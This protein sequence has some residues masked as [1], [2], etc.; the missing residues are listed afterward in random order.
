MLERCGQGGRV[1]MELTHQ[2]GVRAANRRD[3]AVSLDTQHRVVVRHARQILQRRRVLLME[4]L[5][6]RHRQSQ[7][8]LAF[9]LLLLMLRR[10]GCA[11]SHRGWLWLFEPA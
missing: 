3:I 5:A 8:L 4:Q 1:G 2:L 11:A 6:V 10:R 7:E 9:D